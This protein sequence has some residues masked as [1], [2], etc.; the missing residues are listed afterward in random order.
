[1]NDSRHSVYQ[2]HARRW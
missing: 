1:M 2:R